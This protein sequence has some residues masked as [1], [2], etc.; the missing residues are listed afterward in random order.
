MEE[1]SEEEHKAGA[2]QAVP[3]AL[4]CPIP[5]ILAQL[6]PCSLPRASFSLPGLSS[7]LGKV[8]PAARGASGAPC[9]NLPPSPV[10]PRDE[11]PA[12]GRAPHACRVVIAPWSHTSFL[13]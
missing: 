4:A 12:L 8:P 7:C 13:R 10:F 9:P 6:W 1:E 11:P 2:S 3:E 5:T